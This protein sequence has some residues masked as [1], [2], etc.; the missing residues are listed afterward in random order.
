MKQLSILKL[1]LTVIF[2]LTSTQMSYASHFIQK[3]TIEYNFL[4]TPEKIY[5]EKKQVQDIVVK[6]K[7]DQQIN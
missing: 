5:L 7:T 3:D 4:G 6:L 1:I 2:Y